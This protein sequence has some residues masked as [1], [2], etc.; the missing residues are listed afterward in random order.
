MI[1]REYLHIIG[2]LSALFVIC[3]V[4]YLIIRYC[5]N[6]N[7]NSRMNNR[8]YIQQHPQSF[9]NDAPPSYRYISQQQIDTVQPSAPTLY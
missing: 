8:V 6:T 5:C 1:I 4:I 2:Y 7:K 9:Y 3:C